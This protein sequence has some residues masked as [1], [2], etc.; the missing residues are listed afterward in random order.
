MVIGKSDTKGAIGPQSDTNPIARNP[1]ASAT[2]AT[3]SA[4]A[5]A[6]SPAGHQQVTIRYVDR[7]DMPETFADSIA[8]TY[9]DGQTLRIEFTVTRVDEAASVAPIT[10]RR[11]PVC[12]IVVPAPAGIDLINRLN[13]IGATL[14][15]AGVVKP[16][17][18]PT[19]LPK[20][21]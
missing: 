5:P 9:F 16:T 17:P 19:D 6:T 21:T 8:S 18:R 4:P 20:A 13:K 11:F 15:Q 3:T 1:V 7:P 12:R 14:A 10:A 2:R